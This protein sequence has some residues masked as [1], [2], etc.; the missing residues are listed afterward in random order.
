LL[1]ARPQTPWVGFAEVWA[2]KTFCK[3]EQ[4]LFTSFSGKEE[5]ISTF[6]MLGYIFPVSII[7]LG[8]RSWASNLP[9]SGTTGVWGL[10][11]NKPTTLFKIPI[12][13]TLKAIIIFHC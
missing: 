13:Y 7:L 12:Q 3:A 6:F 5:Y 9:R 2:N 10:A 11:P 8:R 1:G 4:T